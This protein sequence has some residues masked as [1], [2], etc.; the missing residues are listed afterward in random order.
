MEETKQ[1][2]ILRQLFKRDASGAISTS[3]FWYNLVN[4]AVVV[5]YVVISWK[6]AVSA[7][8]NLEGFAWLTLVVSAV[9]TGNKIASKAIDSRYR[10]GH[11][12]REEYNLNIN[13]GTIVGK[14]TGKKVESRD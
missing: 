2:T 10:Y 7:N 4:A 9:V 6:V 1:E 14:P 3:I 5:S 8:P 11:G 13:R 12:D